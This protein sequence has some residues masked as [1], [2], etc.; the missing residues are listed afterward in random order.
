MD[1]NAR[2]RLSAAWLLL[3]CGTVCAFLVVAALPA[4]VQAQSK[5]LP[6]RPPTATPT[7]TPLPPTGKP[8]SRPRPAGP[9]GAW[10]ALDCQLAA[11]SR[12]V[13]VPELWTAVQWQD[14]RGR[15]HDVE[16][17]RGQLEAVA[18]GRGTKR[19]WVAQKDFGTGPFR[20]V[21][22]R[23][24]EGALLAASQPFSL[25]RAKGETVRVGIVLSP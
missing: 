17:W 24:Q 5:D 2:D 25:P 23:G 13:F 3:A 10:I 9:G 16:G 6:P 21:V 15:W 11:Q 22:R 7:A 1:M 14:S 8:Q 19:W 20:W 12:S 18:N 4:W